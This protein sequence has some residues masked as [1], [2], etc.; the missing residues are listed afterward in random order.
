M[1]VLERSR[2]FASRRADTLDMVGQRDLMGSG[3]VASWTR[4]AA[5]VRL[6]PK[7][8]PRAQMVGHVAT[9]K[10]EGFKVYLQQELSMKRGP[11]DHVVGVFF[12]S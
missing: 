9:R 2:P 7:I 6:G 1:R 11:F 12:T 10:R 3:S 4:P 5:D 8:S